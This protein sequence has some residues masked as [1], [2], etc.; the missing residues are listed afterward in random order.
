MI[1]CQV[2]D[3]AKL[4]AKIQKRKL[5]LNNNYNAINE[6]SDQSNQVIFQFSMF[7]LSLRG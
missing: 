1:D 5:C 7:A 3:L 6:L 2:N 4:S